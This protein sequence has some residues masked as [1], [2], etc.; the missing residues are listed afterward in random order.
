MECFAATYRKKNTLQRPATIVDSTWLTETPRSHRAAYSSKQKTVR[1][2]A[3][4]VMRKLQPQRVTGI[5]DAEELYHGL[6]KIACHPFCAPR[7]NVASKCHDQHPRLSNLGLH[8]VEWAHDRRHDEIVFRSDGN[9]KVATFFDANS[10]PAHMRET[11][12]TASSLKHSG[13]QHLGLTKASPRVDDDCCFNLADPAPM[14][15]SATTLK[16]PHISVPCDAP[17]NNW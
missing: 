10:T 8:T 1:E 13:D 14:T 3:P 9:A 16:H 12:I 7:V 17:T 5:Y 2:R 4:D 6:Q 15:A 11:N